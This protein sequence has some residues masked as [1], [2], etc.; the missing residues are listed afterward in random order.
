[1]A[2]G[3]GGKD[4]M[5]VKHRGM[6]KGAEAAPE[7]RTDSMGATCNFGDFGVATAAEH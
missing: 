4:D 7:R 1:M 2:G 3:E 6:G 5:I